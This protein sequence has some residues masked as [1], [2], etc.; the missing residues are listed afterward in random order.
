MLRILA[1]A[2]ALG[3]V[4]NAAPGPVFAATVRQ[5]V[6]GGFRSALA[7][8]IG[9]LAG[10]ALW[11]LL[12]LAGVGLLVRFESVRIPIGIAGVAYLLWL[13]WDAWRA[14]RHELM[15][16]ERSGGDTGHTALRTGILLSVTNPQNGGYWAALG[17]ALGA[18]GVPEPGVRDYTAFFTGFMLSSLVWAFLFAAIVDRVLGR[19]RIHWARMTYRLCAILFLALALASLKE[20]LGITMK[21]VIL[22]PAIVLLCALTV[23]LSARSQREPLRPAIDNE[24]VTVWDLRAADNEIPVPARPC[25]FIRLTPVVVAFFPTCPAEGWNAGPAGAVVIELKDHP[26]PPLAN[27]S[28]FPNAFPRPGV[29]KRLENDKILVWDYTWTTGVPTPMHFHDKDVVVVYLENG[30]L[31][32]TTPDGQSVVN[33]LSPRLIRFNARDRI[34]TEELVRGKARA[35]ITELK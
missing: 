29:V 20:L 19:A 14:S 6:R 10:D 35:I 32:S 15:V 13:A 30:A 26:V 17:S 4:F 28:R 23:V 7:V 31:K 11:A 16:A 12:G 24:R 8:Q 1:T 25:V 21:R 33:E 27:P 3:L 18:V 34:H 9:S 5:G 2:F 22:A